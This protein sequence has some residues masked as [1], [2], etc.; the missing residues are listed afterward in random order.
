MPKY[1]SKS[2]KSL[3]MIQSCHVESGSS[4]SDTD[5]EHINKSTAKNISSSDSD[6]DYKK[7]SYS[8]NVSS[9]DSDNDYKKKTRSKN[10]SSS[11]SDSEDESK[12]SKQKS[13]ECVNDRYEDMSCEKYDNDLDM[14]ECGRF[15]LF[16]LKK[17]GYVNVTNLF[18]LFGKNYFAWKR[19]RIENG[20]IKTLVHETKLRKYNLFTRQR[21]F[22]S[23]E[24][25]GKSIDLNG[26]Y[27]HPKFLND[28]LV[29]C[30]PFCNCINVV[31]NMMDRWECYTKS[32]NNVQTIKSTNNVQNI[33]VKEETKKKDELIKSKDDK[34]TEVSNKMDELIKSKDAKIK[35][36]SQKHY[37]LLQQTIKLYS[38][39]EQLNKKTK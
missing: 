30:R 27:V 16:I 15:I 18:K 20:L 19:S 12:S 22:D 13:C 34:I 26:Y 8:K 4:D 9:S 5:Y 37:V 7:T 25:D 2:K 24:L 39:I 1:S 28:I 14:I 11:D 3:P 32:K 33:K 6:D 17:N 31:L 29:W 23:I 35:E 36:I 21:N 10:A 38:K